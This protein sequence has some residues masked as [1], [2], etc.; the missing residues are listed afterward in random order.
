MF[1]MNTVEMEPIVTITDPKIP[2]GLNEILLDK[3]LSIIPKTIK[4]YI[5][6]LI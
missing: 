4:K 3:M 2:P 6:M 1:D 5:E